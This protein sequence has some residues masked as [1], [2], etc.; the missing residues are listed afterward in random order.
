MV[1]REKK[2]SKY[3]VGSHV[4]KWSICDISGKAMA[5]KSK[6][7]SIVEGG[8]MGRWSKTFGRDRAESNRTMS[9]QAI[10][11]SYYNILKLNGQL[12]CE[13]ESSRILSKSQK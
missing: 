8:T 2:K 11:M 4:V 12:E 9:I 6:L 3:I 1:K 5:I 7:S 13:M 10:K